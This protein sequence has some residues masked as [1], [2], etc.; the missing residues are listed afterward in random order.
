M[1]W[2]VIEIHTESINKP[3]VLILLGFILL[4]FDSIF[5]QCKILVIFRIKK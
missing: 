4:I 5:I 2:R 1:G 3:M